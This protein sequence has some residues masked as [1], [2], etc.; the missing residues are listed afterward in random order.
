MMKASSQI[1]IIRTVLVEETHVLSLTFSVI[2]TCSAF[3]DGFLPMWSMKMIC[4]SLTCSF[5]LPMIPRKV[6]S[7][8]A[9]GFWPLT[10]SWLHRISCT[11]VN[12]VRMQRH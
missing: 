11:C 7:C 9:L 2:Q 8:N 1:G 3:D 12:S 6:P 4:P 5:R 10:V